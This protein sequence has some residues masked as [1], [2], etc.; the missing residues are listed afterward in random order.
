MVI[1]RRVWPIPRVPGAQHVLSRK[2]HRPANARQ[3][4]QARLVV[5][6]VTEQIPV[7]VS[8]VRA[9]STQSS[10]RRCVDESSS[11]YQPSRAS[12]PSPR[13]TGPFTR[14]SVRIVPPRFFWFAYRATQST[15]SAPRAMLRPQIPSFERSR[16]RYR[17]CNRIFPVSDVP[18]AA[19]SA[20]LEITPD[21]V[22]SDGKH[23]SGIHKRPSFAY[24]IRMHSRGA[25]AVNR[26]LP[27]TTF[28]SV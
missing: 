15:H 9:L 4:F 17:Y 1:L 16:R 3:R 24:S 23:G 5:R 8:I 19:V 7:R 10:V 11:R 27:I 25:I 12:T 20:Q 22:A 26:A 2:R 28:G 18:C 6:P 13:S 14:S 21:R